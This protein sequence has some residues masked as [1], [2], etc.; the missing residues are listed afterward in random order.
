MALNPITPAFDTSWPERIAAAAVTQMTARGELIDPTNFTATPYDVDTG[1]GGVRT[2]IPVYSGIA[3]VQQLKAERSTADNA[4][5]PTTIR[6]FLVQIPLDGYA[7]K[8][9]PGWWWKTTDGGRDTT[10]LD[11]QLVVKSAPNSSLAAVRTIMCVA[12]PETSP[13]WGA[14]TAITGT[15][16]D[17]DGPLGGVTVR[18]FY[19]DGDYWIFWKSAT[20]NADGSYTISPTAA[21]TQ[22]VIAY[23]KDGYISQVYDGVSGSGLNAG[24]PVA[25]NATDIDAVLVG[26]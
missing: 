2:Y 21:G 7:G 17:I 4:G 14:T 10:L 5:N 19:A 23:A 24:D 26:V 6:D 12:N 16:T 13:N 25:H 22:Y 15:I 11:Y 8:I 3:R 18:A 9:L 1:T 20:T